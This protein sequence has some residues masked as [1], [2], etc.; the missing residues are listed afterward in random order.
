MFSSILSA[1]PIMALL[2]IFQTV[3]LPRFSPLEADPSLPFLVALAWGLLS[4]S[5]EGVIWAFIGGL[6][7]DI[8]TIAPAGGLSLSYMAGVFAASMMSDLLPPN[9]LLFPVI[10]AVVAT[11]LQQLV[12]LLYLRCGAVNIDYADL[13]ADFLD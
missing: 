5:E 8:F 9:R 4:N 13:L 1:V 6:F 11:I 12:Y 10:S 2:T 3:I 7:M